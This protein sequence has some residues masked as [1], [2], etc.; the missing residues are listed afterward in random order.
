MIILLVTSH[1]DHH[2][3]H[4]H[5][6]FYHCCNPPIEVSIVAA[7]GEQGSPCAV[8]RDGDRCFEWKLLQSTTEIVF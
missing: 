3:G 6:H 1:H 8:D 4:H 7:L 2:H 5:H